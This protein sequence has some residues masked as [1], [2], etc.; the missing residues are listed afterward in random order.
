VP[1]GYELLA[2]VVDEAGTPVVLSASSLVETDCVILGS[3]SFELGAVEKLTNGR[4]HL[5]W[6]A[7]SVDPSDAA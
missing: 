7:F 1:R 5:G 4:D 2:D 3:P 6:L